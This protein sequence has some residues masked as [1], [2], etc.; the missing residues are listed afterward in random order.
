MR[1]SPVWDPSFLRGLLFPRIPH[2]YMYKSYIY[3]SYMHLSIL[4]DLRGCPHIIYIPPPLTAQLPRKRGCSEVTA[5]FG[6]RPPQAH[7]HHRQTATRPSRSMGHLLATYGWRALP[8]KTEDC[9]WWGLNPRA[10][11][12]TVRYGEAQYHYAKNG[13]LVRCAE[14]LCGTL[15][16]WGGF[17]SHIYPTLICISHI[18]IKYARIHMRGSLRLP[19]HPVQRASKP[20][21]V[22]QA[23]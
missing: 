8:V 1:R 18:C 20:M 10:L 21:R 9:N 17:F 6:H 15:R 23:K 3:I 16:S 5:R 19:P 13:V 4:E 11:I 14:A 2:P 7:G 12:P 22:Q